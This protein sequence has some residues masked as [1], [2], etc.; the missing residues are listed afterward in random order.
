MLRCFLGFMHYMQDVLY[1]IS[2][3][4]VFTNRQLFIMNIF[5][6]YH[7]HLLLLVYAAL[8]FHTIQK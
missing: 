4:M 1:G 6:C 8:S 7:F 3:Y 5:R 2:M